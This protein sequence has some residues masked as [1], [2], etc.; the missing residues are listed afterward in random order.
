LQFD[1]VNEEVVTR[2]MPREALRSRQHDVP[3]GCGEVIE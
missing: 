3:G 1:V 2:F